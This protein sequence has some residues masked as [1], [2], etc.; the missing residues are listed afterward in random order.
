MGS[1]ASG[2]YHIQSSRPDVF[3]WAENA[4]SFGFTGSDKNLTKLLPKKVPSIID[5]IELNTYR[6]T[7][8]GVVMT[9]QQIRNGHCPYLITN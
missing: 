1:V 3:G 2:Q 6:E 7:T 4:A 8:Q 9:V 5:G